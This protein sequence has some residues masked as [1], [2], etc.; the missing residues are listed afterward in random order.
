[1]NIKNFSNKGFVVLK[2]SISLKLIKL[3]QKNILENIKKK[4]KKKPYK[5][6]NDACKNLED[7]SLFKIINP[8]NKQLFN[9]N[10]I[11]KVLL[12]K[13]IYNCLVSLLGSDLA[14]SSDSSLTIN[15]PKKTKSYYFKD[16][17]QEIW[18][19]A[20]VSNVQIWMPIF[21]KTGID[22]QI[23]FIKES[24]K[25]GHVPH[26]NRKPIKLPENY[27]TVKSKL[28]IGD[29][30]VFSTTLMHKTMPANNPRI[31]LAMTIK[32][33]KYND[34]SYSDNFNWR[35]FSYSEITKIQRLLGNHYLSP[36]RILN[37]NVDIDLN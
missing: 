14:V 2:N 29:A 16:W 1:M 25:W 3:I 12:E 18:S 30:I 5:N 20:S 13:K 15:L 21:Q 6:L 32:N 7:K 26:T 17:H 22:G 28:N 24:H 35:I 4:G 27:Q 34:F 23:N 19:G 10:L 31:A 37:K 9:Q 11:N 36:F 8:I 33:F